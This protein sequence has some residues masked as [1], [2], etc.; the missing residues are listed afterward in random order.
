[1]AIIYSTPEFNLLQMLID[2]EKLDFSEHIIFH[3]VSTCTFT[4]TSDIDTCR[5][6]EKN[7]IVL[8]LEADTAHYSVS[9]TNDFLNTRTL[10]AAGVWSPTAVIFSMRIY[11]NNWNGLRASGVFHICTHVLKKTR[12][13]SLKAL[14]RYWRFFAKWI[15]NSTLIFSLVISEVT[16][17]PC[18]LESGVSL[19]L[20]RRHT[21]PQLLTHWWIF[22]KCMQL[23]LWIHL[24]QYR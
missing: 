13:C 4:Q 1:M 2:S 19:G 24:V 12:G 9:K 7:L 3:E 5:L 20:F 23:C 21:L 8:S 11:R 17:N 6:R 10:I 14:S 22:S 15:L 18:R 16:T